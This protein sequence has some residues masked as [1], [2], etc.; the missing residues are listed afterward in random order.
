[1]Y[2]KS[3]E[4]ALRENANDTVPSGTHHAEKPGRDRAA[5]AAAVAAA[6]GPSEGEKLLRAAKR[7]SSKTARMVRTY[8]PMA[9]IAVF[10]VSAVYALINLPDGIV[11]G[12]S[13]SDGEWTASESAIQIPTIGYL[14][15]VG[16]FIVIS[17]LGRHWIF[18]GILLTI[19][20]LFVSANI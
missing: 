20:L 17:A 4:N 3:Q 1:M 12:A 15:V 9:I 10:L 18:V 6:V 19:H 2:F 7:T 8:L 16:I 14:V 11:A 5:A 13:Y